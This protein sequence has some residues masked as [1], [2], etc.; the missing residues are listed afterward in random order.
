MMP[1][2]LWPL[3]AKGNI[4]L[5]TAEDGMKVQDIVMETLQNTIVESKEA[6]EGLKKALERLEGATEKV[7]KEEG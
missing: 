5:M 4:E 3:G 2:T 6:S 7:E 1:W